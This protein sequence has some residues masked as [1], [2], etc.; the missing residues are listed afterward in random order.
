M[1][2]TIQ[3]GLTLFLGLLAILVLGFN[4]YGVEPTLRHFLARLAARTGTHVEFLSADGNL[5]TGSCKVNGVQI[6]REVAGRNRFHLDIP[7]VHADLAMLRLADPQWQFDA[8]HLLGPKGDFEV[9]DRAAGAGAAVEGG[10]VFEAREVLIQDAD[11]LFLNSLDDPGGSPKRVEVAEWRVDG[12]RSDWSLYDLLYRATA[13]GK[14]EGE[15]FTVTRSAAD[16]HRLVTW[17]LAGLPTD[18]WAG[19]WAAGAAAVAGVADVTVVNRWPEGAPREIAQA[20][21]VAF[22]GG[23]ELTFAGEM[24][25]G[26]FEGAQSLDDAGLGEVVRRGL[27]AGAA[28]AVRDRV[29]SLGR[30]LFGR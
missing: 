22:R 17:K 24:K 4:S 12:Y 29:R 30:R 23:R 27:G 3:R 18:T 8:L 25:R 19:G 7:H 26:D 11:L 1:F 20:W 13:A 16:G 9:V 5:L 6:S 14:I 15:P 10:R 28:G 2:S 21:T